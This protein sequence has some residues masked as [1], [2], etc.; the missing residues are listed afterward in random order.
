MTTSLTQ[1][2]G[3]WVQLAGAGALSAK[4]ARVT[5]SYKPRRA[6]RRSHRSRTC[7]SVNTDSVILCRFRV[8]ALRAVAIAPASAFA[9][10]AVA[11][12]RRHLARRRLGARRENAAGVALALNV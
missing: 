1:S 2:L 9:L 7:R 5:P 6:A 10:S 4:L 8:R 3:Q 12:R 11:L